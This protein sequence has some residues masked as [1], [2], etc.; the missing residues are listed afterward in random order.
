[1]TGV[2][3]FLPLWSYLTRLVLQEGLL[4]GWEVVLATAIAAVV[5]AAV[6]AQQVFFIELP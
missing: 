1:V 4:M 5:H 3:V 2:V 6:V